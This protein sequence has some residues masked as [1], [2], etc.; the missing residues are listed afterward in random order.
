MKKTTLLPLVVLLG[1]APRCAMAEPGN[2]LQTFLNPRGTTYPSGS[3][4]WIRGGVT[5]VGENLLVG[6]PFDDTFG[7]DAGIAYLVDASTGDV[8]RTF[9]SPHPA[10]DGN[11]GCSVAAVGNRVLIGAYH[12]PTEHVKRAGN[13]Y[14]FDAS[15]GKLLHTLVKPSPAPDDRFGWP[16]TV[17]G[18]NFLVSSKWDDTG[19]TNA[20]AVFLYD[21]QTGELLQAFRKPQ[22]SAGDGFGN[23]LAAVGDNLLVADYNDDTKGPDA[24]AAYLFDGSTAQLL[25]TFYNPQPGRKNG[26]GVTAAALGDNVLIGDKSFRPSRADGGIVY[27]FDS[28]TGEVLRTFQNPAP[29]VDDGFGQ[30]IA[31]VDGNVLIGANHAHANGFN[32]GAA[33]LFDGSNGKLLHTFLNPTPAWNDHFGLSTTTLGKNLVITTPF[34]DTVG[35]DGGAVYLFEGGSSAEFKAHEPPVTKAETPTTRL[36][37]RTNPPGAKVHLDGQPIG[38]SPGLFFAPPGDCSVT[39]ELK[40][41]EPHSQPVKVIS[42][43]ITRVEVQLERTAP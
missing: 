27:L 34:D 41:Y 33:Y 26:F 40:G 35:I 8:L 10:V 7:A 24:G 17:L 20:G 21:S 16:A 22:P 23:V 3:H 9:K 37:V 11:F 6:F 25:Q 36:Y 29:A 18:E 5:A 39:V 1:I 42:G 38:T 12:E 30:S 31:V 14:I 2:L 15:T 32:V 28:V 43:Q 19:A 4:F 13:A